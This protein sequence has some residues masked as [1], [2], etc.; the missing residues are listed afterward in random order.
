MI[1]LVFIVISVYS[2]FILL[3]A[4]PSRQSSFFDANFSILFY[5][6]LSH[7]D[8]SPIPAYHIVH[9]SSH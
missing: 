3:T 8:L 9:F 5:Y 1:Y 2:I 7:Y 4:D 6:D